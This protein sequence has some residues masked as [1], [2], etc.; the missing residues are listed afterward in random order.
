MAEEKTIREQAVAA[1]Q[2]GNSV[3]VEGVTYTLTGNK[4]TGAKSL[5]ELPG[6][7]KFT[8]GD[9]A[10]TAQVV[11]RMKQQLSDLQERHDALVKSNKV[12]PKAEAKTEAKVEAKKEG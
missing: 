6:D 7:E 9:A 5:A 1:I 12:E 11:A 10:A 4:E 2:A 8:E 3:N